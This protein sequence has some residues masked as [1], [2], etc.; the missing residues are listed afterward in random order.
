MAVAYANAYAKGLD[1]HKINLYVCEN[2]NSPAG[3]QTCANDMVQQ[4]VVAVIEPFTG[5]GAT[6]V[7]TITKAGIPYITLSGA[8][9]AELT[10][11]GRV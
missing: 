1:G 5:Q 6:E 2:Q 7:P 8:S 3:G 11:P 10:T 4:G 9:E